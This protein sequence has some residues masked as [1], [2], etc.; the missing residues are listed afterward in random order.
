MLKRLFPNTSG[1]TRINS[2]AETTAVQTFLHNV[3]LK[4][5][6]DAKSRVHGAKSKG[7]GIAVIGVGFILVIFT[8][9]FTMMQIHVL[10]HRSASLQQATDTLSDSVAVYMSTD[11]E[12]YGDAVAEAGSL[13]NTIRSA[14][15]VDVGSISVDAGV[16]ED[17][18]VGIQTSRIDGIASTHMS[19]TSAT[20]FKKANM[21]L[22]EQIC[23]FAL[24]WVDQILYP[25]DENGGNNY[26]SNP[27]VL[28]CS[29][30]LHYVFS[31]FGFNVPMGT[32]GGFDGYLH[33]GRNF[34]DINEALPGDIV[35]ID[36]HLGKSGSDPTGHV[37]LYL[38]DGMMC[39][40]SSG[41]GCVTVTPVAGYDVT[42]FTT[43]Y[44]LD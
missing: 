18:I 42:T 21:V 35:V 5:T 2:E 17:D 6:G 33:I 4:L 14:T 34:N 7:N 9:L 25:S 44:G 30:F 28:D 40:S 41:R 8:L 15:G 10:Y 19:A 1:Y 38:G 16:F 31:Q 26:Y 22:R 27:K 24:L 43:P 37:G 3:I 13:S 39:H 29:N 11:G 23:A 32:G 12:E 20:H 36:N